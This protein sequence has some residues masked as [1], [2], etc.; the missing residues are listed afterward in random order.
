MS[1]YLLDTDTLT[2]IQFGH[3]AAVQNLAAHADWVLLYQSSAS[4]L[5]RRRVLDFP[6]ADQ[7][8][9]RFLLLVGNGTCG[10]HGD[11]ATGM[12]LT[13][14]PS[15]NWGPLV[16]TTTPLFTRPCNVIPCTSDPDSSGAKGATLCGMHL[17]GQCLRKSRPLR[18]GA[19]REDACDPAPP[20]RQFFCRISNC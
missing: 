12:T 19:A 1:R 14:V 9:Q 6:K 17:H 11:S 7:T 4:L 2:L 20:R 13:S 15:G 3:A 16:K 10:N 5:H 8:E 18:V